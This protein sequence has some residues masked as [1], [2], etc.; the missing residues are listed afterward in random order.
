[1]MC[2]RSVCGMA[3]QAQAVVAMAVPLATAREGLVRRTVTSVRV[4]RGGAVTACYYSSQ[5]LGSCPQRSSTCVTSY[6]HGAL[7]LCVGL[8]GFASVDCAISGSV[9]R[10]AGSGTVSIAIG[11]KNN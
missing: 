11:N 7:E 3:S 6:M 9:E 4:P 1:M 8:I 2:H 5:S 10:K